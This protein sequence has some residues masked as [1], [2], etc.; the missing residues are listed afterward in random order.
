VTAWTAACQASLTFTISVTIARNPL[1]LFVPLPMDNF[2]KLALCC[3]VEIKTN[4]R[5]FSFLNQTMAEKKKSR[6]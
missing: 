6:K 2:I 5:T 3:V 1:C 4:E